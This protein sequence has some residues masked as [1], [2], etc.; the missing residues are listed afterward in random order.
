MS[1]L[2]EGTQVRSVDDFANLVVRK[3][4]QC[5]LQGIHPPGEPPR[6]KGQGDRNSFSSCPRPM[7]AGSLTETELHSSSHPFHMEVLL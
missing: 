4:G 2:N 5:H 6:E 3:L 7:T 1:K